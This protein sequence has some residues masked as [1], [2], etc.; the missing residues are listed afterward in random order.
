[1]LIRE[2]KILD[3]RKSG[4]SF[5]GAKKLN[6]PLDMAIE[7][8]PNNY[9]EIKTTVYSNVINPQQYDY[10]GKLIFTFDP[11]E[12]KQGKITKVILT[13]KDDF[14]LEKILYL[15]ATLLIYDKSKSEIYKE[16]KDELLSLQLAEKLFLKKETVNENST[17]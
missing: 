11:N 3:N 12:I 15:S 17:S 16:T 4:F 10:S 1:M 9:Y 14:L 8:N 2:V 13:R 6:I 5:T 7:I